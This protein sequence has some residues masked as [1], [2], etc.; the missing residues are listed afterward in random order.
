MN[1]LSEIRADIEQTRNELANT[2]GALSA[3]LD[4]KAQAKGHLRAV[5]IRARARYQQAKAA[6]PE[7]LRRVL[8][9]IE[10]TASS[11]A[12]RAKAAPVG[13]VAI[14]GGTVLVVVLLRRRVQQRTAQAGSQVGSK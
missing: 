5:R 9:M 14:G 1:E 3:K 7:P 10:H 8:D 12:A 11:G 13:A 2:V 6:L 4:V